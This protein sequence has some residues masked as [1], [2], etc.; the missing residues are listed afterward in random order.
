M[1]R[2]DAQQLVGSLAE[3][4]VGARHAGHARGFHRLD[5][6]DLVAHQADR[7]GR[8]ADE[9][10]A[11][12]LDALREVRVLG[13]EAVARMDRDR[14]GDLGRADDAPAC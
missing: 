1:S 2:A 4:A 14:V 5:R 11:A 8:G 12:L 3:R 13:Q 6:R 9:R 10:E 7:L